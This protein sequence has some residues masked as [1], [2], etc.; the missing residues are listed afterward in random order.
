MATKKLTEKRATELQVLFDTCVIRENRLAEVDRIVDRIVEKRT[1]Y[2]D[3]AVPFDIP[4]YVL[5]VIHNMEASLKFTVHLHNGDPLSERT[6]RVPKGRPP[7]PAEP[8]FTWEESARDAVQF[9]GLD[10][11]DDWSIPVM[12]H[13]LEGYNGY[14]YHSKGI[15]SPY[16]WSFSFH[17]TKG[18]FVEDGVYDADAVSKQ[19]GAA[20]LL[21]RMADRNVAVFDATN[22]AAG[23]LAPM[24]SYNPNKVTEAARQLQLALNRMPGIFLEADGRA[25]RAT[26]DALRRVTGHY[27]I[28]DPRA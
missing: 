2:E 6:V 5:G 28:G 15:Q 10:D 19:A 25:G 27:L 20:V 22:T 9:D 14:G 1:R 7:L 4:W 11:I 12:L 18:K 26:S 23:D 21:R 8:P 16:L 24:V 17:Y 13:R 3:V